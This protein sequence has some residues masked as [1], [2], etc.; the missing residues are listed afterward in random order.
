MHL[1][2]PPSS[3]LIPPHPSSS[4]IRAIPHQY[5]PSSLLL[6][7]IQF[8]KDRCIHLHLKTVTLTILLCP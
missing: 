2:Q 8:N 7:S 4:P 3:L 1:P 6:S 5:H